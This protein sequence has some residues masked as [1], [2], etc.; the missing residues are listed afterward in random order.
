MSPPRDSGRPLSALARRMD[1]FRREKKL[2]APGDAV[3]AAL[4]GGA[5]S[6]AL[7][8]LL[9]DLDRSGRCPLELR[10]AHLHHGFDRPGA[11]EDLAFSRELAASLDVPFL[12]GRVDAP[13]HARRTGQ[14]LEAA[15]R[16]LRYAFLEEKA[17]GLG[18]GLV[19][20]GH[21]LDDQAETVL[22]RILRGTG[23][24][25]LAAILP[26]RPLEPGSDVRLVRPLLPFPRREIL[27]YLEDRGAPFREDP[28]NRDPAFAR[29][30]LR[31]E[32]MPLLLSM[33]PGVVA[34]LAGLAE[35]A[36]RLREAGVG[37]A[38]TA[39]GL[40]RPVMGG[41]DPEPAFRE[42]YRR[43]GGDPGKLGR[44]HLRALRSMLEAAG[45][46]SLDLPEGVR[47]R[48]EAEGV[49]LA[50][51]EGRASSIE[52]AALAVPGRVEAGGGSVA[53]S[54]TAVPPPAE[55]GAGAP[56][57]EHVDAGAV[58]GPLRVRSRREGDRF[59]P[60]GSGGTQSLKEFFR[61]EGVDPAVRDGVPLVED[62]S[63]R[64][65]WV[66]GH[67]IAHWARITPRTQWAIRLE[68]V[69]G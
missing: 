42:A 62:G 59:H 43:A 28:S 51:R 40:V 24:R 22:L 20:T 27:A 21:T 56:R 23:L 18:A 16:E 47:A 67:R 38:L 57:A 17:R 68:L 44:V 66:A 45:P 29:N 15:A 53:A 1:A 9:R 6:T 52:P 25:G 26:A 48:R 60:L 14:G 55:L 30:R 35:E 33:H 5:D 54:E 7:L 4:S 61:S 19:A 69:E 3:V 49:R 46:S 13:A 34:S 37:A 36:Q 58:Q 39:Q 12:A 11:E 10:A 41:G 2:F 31:Q 8:F 64:I 65:V 50:A 63:G 32:V